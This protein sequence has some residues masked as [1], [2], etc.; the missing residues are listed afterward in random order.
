MQLL[1]TKG[2]GGGEGGKKKHAHDEE[3]QQK[4]TGRGAQTK[5]VTSASV[6]TPPVGKHASTQVQESSP[7][8]WTS[9]RQTADG[10]PRMD[11]S[12]THTW[13]TWR[14]LLLTSLTLSFPSPEF[15]YYWFF[16]PLASVHLASL[17]LIFPTT[18]FLS[19]SLCSLPLSYL[20]DLINS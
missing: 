5:I 3:G 6:K 18:D 20:L 11:G 10:R 12:S 16:L 14:P 15:P 13:T 9:A 17:P 8:R 4:P 19:P 7:L 1:E 2:E